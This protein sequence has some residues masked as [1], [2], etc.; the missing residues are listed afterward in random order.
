MTPAIL[1][2]VGKTLSTMPPIWI[3]ETMRIT[4]DDTEGVWDPAIR[5]I[6][7]KRNKLPSIPGY[8]STL[9]HEVAHATTGA[10]DVSRQFE[11]VLTD[12][13]GRTAVAAIGKCVLGGK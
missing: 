8:A 7:I 3:S 13:L 12:Y 5:T 2:L 11:S 10:V 9:L 4:T 1:A 6:V